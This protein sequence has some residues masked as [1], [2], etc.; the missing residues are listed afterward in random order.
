MAR[1][2]SVERKE[3][4]TQEFIAREIFF[5]FRNEGKSRHSQIEE[6]LREFVTTRVT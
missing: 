4:S 2:S 5:F 6:K 3:L 1:F